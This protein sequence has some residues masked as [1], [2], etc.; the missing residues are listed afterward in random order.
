M[1][2][3]YHY[4]LLRSAEAPLPGPSWITPLDAV[5]ENTACPQAAIPEFIQLYHGIDIKQD[6][7]VANVYAPD[8]TDKNL[9]VL[10]VVHGGGFQGGHG[11]ALKPK[12]IV[13]THNIITVTFNYRLGIHGFLCLGTEN[14]PGN[15][16]MKDQVALLRWVKMN[17]ANFGGNPKDVTITGYS[18]GSAS[19]ELLMLSPMAKGLFNKVI[20]ES[21]SALGTFA[22]QTDPLENAQQLAKHFNIE[23]ADDVYAIEEFYK[24]ASFETITSDPFFHAKDSSFAFSPCVETDIG[25]EVF[26]ADSP[27]NILKSGNYEKLPLLVGFADSEGLLRFPLFETWK[28]DMNEK[29]SDFLPVNLKF[30]NNEEKEKVAKEIKEFYFKDKKVD[31]DTVLSY[32]DFF[33]DALFTY[34]TLK[35][36]EYNVNAGNDKVFVYFYDYVNELMPNIP[37]TNVKGAPHC[38]QT[39]AVFDGDLTFGGNEKDLPDNYKKHKAT[40][41]QF[42]S[43]FIKTGVPVPE[44]SSLPAWPATSADGSPYMLLGQTVEL[45]YDALLQERR[46]LWETV[47]SRHYRAPSR[48]HLFGMNSRN[49]F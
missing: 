31:N 22:V 21:G 26:L 28:N 17:I 24:S 8:T 25:Q 36:V 14:A 11:N 45:R 1:V 15:A 49:E 48:P 37:Y 19:V 30:G 3:P 5:K 2:N 43:N 44:G 7:L 23:H 41:R 38:A 32:I 16:G 29:F 4:S 46:R 39:F 13:A 9:P 47:Y 10:V 12:K 18:A 35:A 34:S 40:V 42:W 6:C 33:S 27:S 20:A